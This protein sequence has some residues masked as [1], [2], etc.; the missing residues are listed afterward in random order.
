MTEN[1]MSQTML[2]MGLTGAQCFNVAGPINLRPPNKPTQSK[3]FLLEL[4][5]QERTK[6]IDTHKK[7]DHFSVMSMGEFD[8]T[9]FADQEAVLEVFYKKRIRISTARA[10]GSHCTTHF[11]SACVTPRPGPSKQQDTIRCA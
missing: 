1:D 2:H 9:T 11:L 7:K 8:G 3:I 4:N 5:P 10:S 6:F